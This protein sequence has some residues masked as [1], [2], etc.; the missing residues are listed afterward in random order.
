MQALH[1]ASGDPGHLAARET[2]ANEK[3]QA[4]EKMAEAGAMLK[5]GAMGRGVFFGMKMAR[6]EG[7]HQ[8][9]FARTTSADAG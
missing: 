2:L 5:T 9:L 4:A 8:A 1:L 7:S 6:N 3:L